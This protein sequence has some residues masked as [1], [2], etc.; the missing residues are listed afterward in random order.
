[1]T[2]VMMVQQVTVTRMWVYSGSGDRTVKAW[3]PN[4]EWLLR[5]TSS[6][7]GAH[8][9]CLVHSGGFSGGCQRVVG[10]H[11]SSLVATGPLPD[12]RTRL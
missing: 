8:S 11:R 1:M 6:Y 12:G 3:A 2:G 4:A 10:R 9:T 5:P 7:G